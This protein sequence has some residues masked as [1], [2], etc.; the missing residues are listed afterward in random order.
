MRLFLAFEPSRP[1]ARGIYDCQQRLRAMEGMPLLWAPAENWHVTAHFL[2]EVPPQR[3]PGLLHT[4]GGAVTS[5]LEN[6][7][8]KAA[9]SPLTLAAAEWFPG[10]SKPRLLALCGGAPEALRSF[11]DGIGRCL[12]R[13]GFRLESRDWRPHLTL[14][15]LKGPR[16]H[17][18]PPPL[19]PLPP[20]PLQLRELTLFESIPAQGPPRYRPVERFRMVP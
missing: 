13:E 8:E 20:V 2:G 18:T 4:V 6:G 3:L 10:P 11:R 15:R 12:R 1:E 16:K 7:A 14:A 9:E 5:A 17:F 19:P